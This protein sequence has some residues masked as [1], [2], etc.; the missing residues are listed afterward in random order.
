MTQITIHLDN[1]KNSPENNP[2]GYNI[3]VGGTLPNG[4]EGVKV[5]KTDTDVTYICDDETNSIQTWYYDYEWYS[6]ENLNGPFEDGEHVEL[7]EV[8]GKN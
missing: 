3:W 4:T 6:G 5:C 2:P 8:S 7:D 1:T